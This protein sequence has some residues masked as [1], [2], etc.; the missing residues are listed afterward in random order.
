[1]HPSAIF[2]WGG[3][4]MNCT[5]QYTCK[6]INPIYDFENPTLNSWP[7]LIHEASHKWGTSRNEDKNN[8]HSCITLR[9][10]PC[11]PCAA[12]CDVDLFAHHSAAQN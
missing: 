9:I 10:A 6:M 2:F 8:T 4:S 11:T 1:M 12:L 3:D 7:C 5:H